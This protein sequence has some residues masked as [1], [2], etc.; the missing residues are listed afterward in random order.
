MRDLAHMPVKGR[1]IQALLFLK[2][3]F[4]IDT[5]GCIDLTLSRQDLASYVGATYETVFRFL[6]ELIAEKMIL[7]NG[8][9]IKLLKEETLKKKMLQIE[10]QKD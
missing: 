9:K 5:D 4:G 1:M 8:K 7:V 3:R 2:N 6:T 10:P